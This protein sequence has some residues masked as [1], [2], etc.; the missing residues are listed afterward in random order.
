LSAT[1][2]STLKSAEINDPEGLEKTT[3]KLSTGELLTVA[4]Q[5]L[6]P[7]VEKYKN[8]EKV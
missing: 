2:F 7:A 5:H 1:Q 6:T 8:L 4:T 3:L